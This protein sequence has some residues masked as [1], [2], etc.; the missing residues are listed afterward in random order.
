M[1]PLRIII[2]F[3]DQLFD[4]VE[5]GGILPASGL[6]VDVESGDRPPHHPSLPKI[7]SLTVDGV[8][9]TQWVG[10]PAGKGLHIGLLLDQSLRDPSCVSVALEDHGQV[11]LGIDK[12]VAQGFVDGVRNLYSLNPPVFRTDVGDLKKILLFLTGIN[13]IAAVFICPVTDQPQ[14]RVQSK[15]IEKIQIGN[16][17]HMGA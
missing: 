13:K 17:F 11:F 1:N 14:D 3:Q 16:A 7:F 2:H 15:T 12:S 9:I 4:P 10:C 8:D 5:N 6:A